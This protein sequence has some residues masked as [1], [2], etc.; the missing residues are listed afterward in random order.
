MLFQYMQRL[1]HHSKEIAVFSSECVEYPL[2]HHRWQ[3]PTSNFQ[4]ATRDISKGLLQH[5]D[6]QQKEWLIPI[7]QQRWAGNSHLKHRILKGKNNLTLETIAKLE[8]ALDF[9]I[10]GNALI[11]VDGYSQST[12]P[13]RKVYLSDSEPAPYGEKE[14]LL[15]AQVSQ[16]LR[17]LQQLHI[18]ATS[19]LA[20]HH[21][22]KS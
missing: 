5:V 10:I 2:R 1:R 12:L 4:Q 16:L 9:D 11:P 17:F 6:M 22:S 18:F 7:S 13:S 3:W 20:S 15:D 19:P 21:T 14:W 8:E